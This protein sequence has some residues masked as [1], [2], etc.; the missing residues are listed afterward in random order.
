MA[1]PGITN[2]L[3][4]R[5]MK[6]SRFSGLKMV[7]ITLYDQ[8]QNEPDADELAEKILLQSSDDR[9]AYKRTYAERFD[10][11]DQK[12]IRFAVKNF[13]KQKPLSV[14][15]AGV[16]DGRTA[17]D[18]FKKLS[19]V[20]ADLD[21]I[22]SDYSP[23]VYVLKQ[24]NNGRSSCAVTID[25]SSGKI[26]EILWPP[27]VF[28]CMKSI[29][30]K[31]Y[32]VNGLIYY[33]LLHTA[34]RRILNNYKIGNIQPK[35]IKL[36]SPKVLS[37]AK[38]DKRFALS[39]HSVLEPFNRQY[40][41][42]RIMNLLNLSYFSSAEFKTIVKIVHAGLFDG[43]MFFAGSNQDAGS[44]VDGGIYIKAGSGFKKI[45]SSGQGLPIDQV[46]TENRW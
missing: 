35:E 43:G 10:V 17:L 22:A 44:P 9:G 18:F 45:F 30:G 11:F 3:A 4:L 2:I 37:T 32:P 21:F 27:F 19:S 8:I 20:F 33:I 15:D 26:L 5:T 38:N 12:A 29:G 23:S 1:K 36:F 42:I 6:S 39:K 16:S 34:V 31:L 25:P 13:D 7:T 14:H 41:M 24:Y 28:N 46:I 40:H